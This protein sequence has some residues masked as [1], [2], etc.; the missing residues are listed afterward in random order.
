MIPLPYGEHLLH[1]VC[2]MSRRCNDPVFKLSPEDPYICMK[3]H[4]V[5]GVFTNSFKIERVDPAT[6]PPLR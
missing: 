5:P 1:I 6:M 3:V 4:M 2:G